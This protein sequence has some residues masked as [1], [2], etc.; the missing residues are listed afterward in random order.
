MGFRAFPEESKIDQILFFD[1]INT[2][3]GFIA[4]LAAIS[5]IMLAVEG[6]LIDAVPPAIA[7]GIWA[8]IIW[9]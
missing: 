9:K 4:I 5:L 2:A 1:P 6:M 8:W 7:S 3:L